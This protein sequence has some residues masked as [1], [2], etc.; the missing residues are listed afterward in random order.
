ML[1]T[2][3][4]TSAVCKPKTSTQVAWASQDPALHSSRA[5]HDCDCRQWLKHTTSI[6]TAQCRGGQTL[7]WTHACHARQAISSP[8]SKSVTLCASHIPQLQEI[9]KASAA[10]ASSPPFPWNIPLVRVLHSWE[11][12][13]QH[14]PFMGH[15]CVDNLWPQG[16]LGAMGGRQCLLK[17]ATVGQAPHHRPALT[18]RTPLCNWVIVHHPAK[19]ISRERK[20]R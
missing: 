2:T 19:R 7:P 11:T 15:H 20:S 4:K 5:K 13:F 14:H 10:H 18:Q 6:T 17:E 16:P 1:V 3:N 9:Q 12:P 8:L